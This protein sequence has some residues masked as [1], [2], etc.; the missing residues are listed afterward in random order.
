[1]PREGD[2]SGGGGRLPGELVADTIEE[3][4]AMLP[5]GLTRHAR[6]AYDPIGTVEAW[7]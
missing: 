1:M 2:H 4:R 5:A 3:V 6:S 7:D